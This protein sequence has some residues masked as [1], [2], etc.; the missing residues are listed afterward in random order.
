MVRVRRRS[1]E[2]RASI[3]DQAPHIWSMVIYGQECGRG[4]PLRVSARRGREGAVARAGEARRAWGGVGRGAGRRRVRP[5][6][7]GPAG[8]QGTTLVIYG[9]TGSAAW[10]RACRRRR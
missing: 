2:A 8:R 10:M 1:D 5:R 9:A 3:D 6:R 4:R 7:P